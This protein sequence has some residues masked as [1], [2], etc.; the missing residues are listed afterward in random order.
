MTRPEVSIG[1]A[2]TA[3][4]GEIALM[5]RDLVESGLRW[6]WVPERVAASVRRRDA[7]VVIARARDRIA[8][9]GIM[10]YGDDD[11]HL[12]LLGV[13]HD[14]RRRGVGSRLVEWLEKPA[15]VAG[16][17][18]VFL[19]VRARNRGAQAFYERL[20]YRKLARIT[21]YYEGRESAIRMGR[22]LGCWVKRSSRYG[23]V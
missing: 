12:D 17:S 6:S 20:E 7:L 2:R 19:E 16:I 18:A 1:L 3:D 5:S 14:Y 8:G 9:F 22:E 15:L 4:A 10:R 21:G 13:A 23:A 11:A